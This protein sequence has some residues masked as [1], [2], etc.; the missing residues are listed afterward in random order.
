MSLLIGIGIGAVIVFVSLLLR[1][2]Y[3]MI[4][5]LR[6]EIATLKRRK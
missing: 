6:D 2:D 3:L 4:K 1:G 5:Q